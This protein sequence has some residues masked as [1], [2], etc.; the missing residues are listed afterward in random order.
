[1]DTE[2][3]DHICTRAFLWGNREE[4]KAH[5]AVNLFPVTLHVSH[6]MGKQNILHPT[7]CN[8]SH[9]VH[10]QHSSVLCKQNALVDGHS[11]TD[12]G[13]I[14]VLLPQKL[15]EETLKGSFLE[16]QKSGFFFF[17]SQCWMH[18]GQFLLE[19]IPVS[20][21]PEH[22]LQVLHMQKFSCKAYTYSI[23]Y[24]QIIYIVS[25]PLDMCCSMGQ[26]SLEDFET[27][28]WSFSWCPLVEFSLNACAVWVTPDSST[29]FSSY[30][31]LNQSQLVLTTKLSKA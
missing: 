7:H 11:C 10:T 21:T 23:L 17:S 28:C 16:F 25:A 19:C 1:M 27:L 24:P 13:K 6:M 2:K 8:P 12:S 14:I 9:L 4:K 18:W 15:V 26:W 31:V 5:T 29:L 3:T 30:M 22:T 20:E